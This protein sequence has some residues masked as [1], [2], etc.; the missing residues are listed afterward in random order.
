M[1]T[2]VRLSSAFFIQ[3]TY[4]VKKEL[5]AVTPLPVSFELI[6]LSIFH[7]NDFAHDVAEV[8]RLRRFVVASL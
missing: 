1:A 4:K 2:L 3:Q 7:S 8:G 6:V 5:E